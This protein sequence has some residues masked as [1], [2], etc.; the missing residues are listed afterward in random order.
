MHNNNNKNYTV[1][2]PT[3]QHLRSITYVSIVLLHIRKMSL[4][5]LYIA[6]NWLL[7]EL[8]WLFILQGRLQRFY[9]TFQTRMWRYIFGWSWLN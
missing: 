2:L 1:G 4:L 8:N 9:K 7:F 3:K 5:M 6:S